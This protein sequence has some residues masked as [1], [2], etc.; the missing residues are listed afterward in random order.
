MCQTL[1]QAIFVYY[2]IPHSS[3]VKEVL[4][5]VYRR[6]NYGMGIP[7]E[8]PHSLLG[9]QGLLS[10][11]SLPKLYVTSAFSQTQIYLLN[12]LDLW[13]GLPLRLSLCFSCLVIS[14]ISHLLSQPTSE[15]SLYSVPSG[16]LPSVW[17]RHALQKDN[18]HIPPTHLHRS[19]PAEA[20]REQVRFCGQQ[21]FHHW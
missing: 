11:I 13:P 15:N 3:L 14:R 19:F 5:S 10:V 2:F 8:W 1:F 18:H 9:S 12:S 7:E 21:H 6:R 4:S 20:H 16:V 17:S